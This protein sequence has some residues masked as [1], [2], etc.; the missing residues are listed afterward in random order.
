[1]ARKK[2]N[3]DDHPGHIQKRGNSYR[4]TLCVDGKYTRFS[5]RGDEE[6]ARA[7]AKRRYED[8]RSRSTAGLPGPMRFSALLARFEE[9]K[10]PQKAPN[11]R[12][13]Y[14]GSLK[15]FRA[16]FVDR[17]RDLPAHELRTPHVEGF[18]DWRRLHRPDG[19]ARTK[20]LSARSLSK[21][22]AVLHAVFRYGQ[23]L[24]VVQANPVKNAERPKGDAREPL[25]LSEEQFE[26]LLAACEKR[27]MLWLYA[28]VL[29]ETGVR[30]D[31]EALWLRWQDV[32]LERGFLTVESVRKGQRTKSGKSRKV[33]LTPRLR[34]A[35]RE[36][37]A[38]FRLAV[39]RGAR[40]EWVFH[41]LTSRRTAT[42]GARVKTLR[43]AF[44]NAVKRAKLPADLNQHDLRHR[45]V[46][47]WLA[48]G[49]SPALVQKAMG[50]SDLA[51]TM[52]YAHLVSGDLLALVESEEERE[53]KALAQ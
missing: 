10:L 8:L 1:M 37:A 38:T 31:S 18:I 32:D 35:L 49:K 53:L 3:D 21:D 2:P 50:H 6:K 51:T 11:T 52:K 17:G 36:H 28:L 4:V 12:K 40:S 41:H 34:D 27:P 47:T 23:R 24:E 16:Y 29:G 26:K 20:P 43:G 44:A 48:A 22:R 45:R 15:A 5:V 7:E 13:T 19:S 39:Y 9:V 30:C 33:P 14:L 42:A 25:I 46:T